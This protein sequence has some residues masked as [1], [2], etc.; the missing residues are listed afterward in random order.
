MT[1]DPSI[2][3]KLGI[4]IRKAIAVPIEADGTALVAEINPDDWHQAWN[5][6]RPHVDAL[7]RWPVIL[8][9]QRWEDITT[10]WQFARDTFASSS[11]RLDMTVRAIISRSESMNL[12]QALRDEESMSGHR[13][14]PEEATRD[15]TAATQNR[16]GVS[17]SVSELRQAAAGALDAQLG[18]ERYLLHWESRRGDLPKNVQEAMAHTRGYLEP[19]PPGAGDE[20]VTLILLP[21]TRPWEVYAYLEGLWNEPPDR[22]VAAARRWHERY[23]AEPVQIHPGY[24]THLRVP[25]PPKDLEEAWQLAREHFLIAWDT[26]ILAGITV[27][28]YARALLEATDWYLKSKP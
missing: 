2:F 13:P 22:L 12:D 9:I 17:P 8:S 23:S 4:T 3:G 27:R 25:R 21:T 19:P 15:A 5:A 11:P 1:D 18:V 6:V 28:D 10:G 24:A 20:P 7:G 14:T 26:F 16:W